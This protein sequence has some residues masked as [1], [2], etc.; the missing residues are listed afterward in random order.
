MST[1]ALVADVTTIFPESNGVRS[2][3]TEYKNMPKLASPKTIV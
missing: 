1:L 3:V 2:Y